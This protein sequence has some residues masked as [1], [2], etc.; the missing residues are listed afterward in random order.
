MPAVRFAKMPIINLSSASVF[1]YEVLLR[2]YGDIK[3]ARFNQD[4][5]LFIK[6][7][8]QLIAA[9]SALDQAKH[10]RKKG[11]KLFLNLIPQQLATPQVLEAITA[12]HQGLDLPLVIEVT[13][14]GLSSNTSISNKQLNNIRAT[15]CQL[16][17]D[18][19]G[20]EHSNFR[21]VV[22][23]CPHYIKLDQSFIQSR[24]WERSKWHQLRQLIILFHQWDKKVIIEGVETK[25]QYQLSEWIGA[26]YAQGYYFGLPEPI[27]EYVGK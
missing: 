20:S 26:D 17:I 13:E 21:R 24:H 8:R 23:L 2:Q 11:Q 27:Q 5:T 15:G 12:L 16:A 1:S 25:K 7:H 22:E 9:L 6:Y 4:P 19:F 14:A 3:L 18:D 10:I